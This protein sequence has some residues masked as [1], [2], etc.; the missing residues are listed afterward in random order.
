MCVCV[1]L[2]PVQL[3]GVLG[4]I[5]FKRY[6]QIIVSAGAFAT[7]AVKGWLADTGVGGGGG[8]KTTHKRAVVR[9]VYDASIAASGFADTLCG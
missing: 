3:A 6:A 7:D 9:G 1:L 5:K 8:G 2:T 4:K